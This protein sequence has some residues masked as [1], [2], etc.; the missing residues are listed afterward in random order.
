[1]HLTYTESKCILSGGAAS[2]IAP[3]HAQEVAILG[4]PRKLGTLK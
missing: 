3:L 1:M 4:Q 2:S